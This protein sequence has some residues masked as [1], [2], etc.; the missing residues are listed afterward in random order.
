MNGAF[1]YNGIDRLNNDE[2]YTV[3]NTV[4]CCSVCNRAKHTMGFEA[5]R[6][7]IAR[8]YTHIYK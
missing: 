6:A 5:F 1:T 4:T 3:E 2:G 7:W 8:V